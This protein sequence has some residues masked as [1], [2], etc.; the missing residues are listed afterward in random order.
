MAHNGFRPDLPLL[1]KKINLNWRSHRPWRARLDKQTSKTEVPNRRYILSTI[2][3][4]I[5][6]H[7]LDRIDARGSPPGKR[8]EEHTSELQSRLHLVCRLLLEKKNTSSRTSSGRSC[9]PPHRQR[10]WRRHTGR[11]PSRGLPIRAR[12]LGSCR[13]SGRCSPC[14]VSAPRC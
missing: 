9:W 7:A 8:S 11:P 12:R 14:A 3:A 4:P 10:I 5:D 2:A 1:Y 6:R 13:L